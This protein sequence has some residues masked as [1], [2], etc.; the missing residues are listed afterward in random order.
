MTYLPSKIQ[1]T[2]WP[3][4]ALQQST[5]SKGKNSERKESRS[6]PK[7]VHFINSIIVLT[8]D[9]DTEEEDVSST[10]AR[11]HDLESMMRRKEEAREQCKEEDEMGTVDEVEELFED[12]ESERETEEEVEEVFNDE[13]EEEEDDDTKYYNSPPAIKEL[14]YHEWLLENP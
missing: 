7:R 1:E 14:A 9:S 6:C 10:N 13:T 5:M 12:E 4:K 2:P 11:E 3:P 8:K